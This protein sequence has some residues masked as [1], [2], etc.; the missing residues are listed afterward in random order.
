MNCCV[1][2]TTYCKST[3]ILISTRSYSL[4][5]NM[6][7]D[8]PL[9]EAEAADAEGIAS[10]FAQSWR[11]PFS[12]LQF[13]M[14]DSDLDTLSAAL[15]PRIAQQMR[16]TA[17]SFVVV[18]NPATKEVVAVAQWTLPAEDPGLTQ[19]SPDDQDERQ[20]LEDEVFRKNLPANSNK[21]LIMDFTT[22]LRD[23]RNRILQGQRH[24]LLDNLATHA[25]YQ[26]QGLARRLIEQ[27]LQ[28]ADE[29]NVPVYLETASDNP[30]GEMYR[31]LGFEEQG[32]H[33]LEDLGRY[34][35]REEL[36]RC[37][38]ISAHTHVAFVR[39]RRGGS[40]C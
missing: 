9:V 39:G 16:L 29:E 28:R 25:S 18:R 34:A 19:E 31:R 27:V 22:G 11:S 24:Y 6:S 4:N 15:A 20:A 40:W 3:C 8:W 2:S 7:R 23:L 30:A 1:A 12:R 37:E 21:E 35:T 38:G 32:R 10:L 13:A 5:E 33:V 17:V 26:R 14:A 36:E